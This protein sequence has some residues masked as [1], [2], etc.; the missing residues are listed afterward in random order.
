MLIKNKIH[1]KCRKRQGW[2]KKLF[3]LF[4]DLSRKCRAIC[5]D[6]ATRV[7]DSICAE[8]YI[9]SHDSSEFSPASICESSLR[10]S[11]D[12]LVIMTPIGGDRSWCEVHIFPSDR[13]DYDGILGDD[14]II[15]EI[16]IFHFRKWSYFCIIS[17]RGIASDM[18]VWSNFTVFT[19]V[20]IPFD[21]GS[22]FEYDP[23]FEIDTS[24]DSD[25]ILDE[26]SMIDGLGIASYDWLIGFQEIPRISYR[27]PASSRFHD[28]VATFSHICC[29]E[30]CDFEL[31]SWWECDFL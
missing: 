26:C 11:S 30:I 19:E 10:E 14:R 5:R 1:K 27:D 15:I 3:S 31:S 6:G 28:R 2:Y 17:E 4:Y 8:P 24:L 23:F 7:S 12:I 20:D 21:I 16:A 29:Y 22:R 13:I 18:A 25:M 9:I